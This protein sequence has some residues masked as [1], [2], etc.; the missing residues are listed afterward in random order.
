LPPDARNAIVRATAR[1]A[2]R[3]VGERTT[4]VDPHRLPIDRIYVPVKRKKTL[5]PERVRTLAESILERGLEEAIEVRADG[6][7]FVL[8]EGLHRLEAARALGETL[9]AAVEVTGARPLE[10]PASAYEAEAQA[11][12]EKTERLRKLRLEQS[13]TS[14]TDG[15]AGSPQRRPADPPATRE[16]SGGRAAAARPKT[17]AEWIVRQ[18][19]SGGRF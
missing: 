4:V 13:A 12:R 14:G 17:L 6:D 18:R 10:R 11:Q 3:K 16:R 9:I 2:E 8:V 1:G 19:D 5:E 15:S 7:R